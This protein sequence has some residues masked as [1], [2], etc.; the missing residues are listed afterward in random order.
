MGTSMRAEPSDL[1]KQ[2]ADKFAML[3]KVGHDPEQ[4]ALSALDMVCGAPCAARG[5]LWLAEQLQ[6]IARGLVSMAQVPPGCLR[7]DQGPA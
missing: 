6:T 3:V 1:E 2:L 4:V 7:I 5:P